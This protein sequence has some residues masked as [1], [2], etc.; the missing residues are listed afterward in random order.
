MTPQEFDQLEQR[1][2]NSRK[3]RQEI[4]ILEREQS[5]L[6]ICNWPYDA[7]HKI[8]GQNQTS[9]TVNE[10]NPLLVEVFEVLINT[11]KNKLE[12]L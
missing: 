7:F 8:M 9:V 5:N 12:Q 3:L 4:E 6:E 1:L 2:N 10:V 11:R